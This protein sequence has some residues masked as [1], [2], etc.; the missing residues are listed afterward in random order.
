M[1]AVAINGSPRK[2][3][4]TGILLKK[5]LAP[6]TAAGW[7]TEFIQLGGVPIRGCRACYH[8]F[9]AKDLC[10]FMASSL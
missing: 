5:A 8:C 2:G 7:Q 10:N 9:D 6:L 1:K 3:G 4:N